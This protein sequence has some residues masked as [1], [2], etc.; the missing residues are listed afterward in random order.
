MKQLSVLLL[1]S[2]VSQCCCDPLNLVYNKAGI[3]F[4]LFHFFFV[5]ISY[6]NKSNKINL[7]KINKLVLNKSLYSS[8]IAS[9][10]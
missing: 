9:I 2:L 6:S 1:V 7:I 3:G 8:R 10:I 4:G 5:T